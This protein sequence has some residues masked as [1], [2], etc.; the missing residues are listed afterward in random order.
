[1][2]LNDLRDAWRANDWGDAAMDTKKAAPRAPHP[3]HRSGSRK[4]WDLILNAMPEDVLCRTLGLL[5]FESSDAPTD[6]DGVKA[7]P[8]PLLPQSPAAA[9]LGLPEH[10]DLAKLRERAA[11]ASRLAVVSKPWQRLMKATGA[12]ASLVLRHDRLVDTFDNL[13]PIVERLGEGG[14]GMKHLVRARLLFKEEHGREPTAA[15]L[16]ELRAP[17]HADAALK[18]LTASCQ[19]VW[20][21]DDGSGAFRKG[22][23]FDRWLWDDVLP[24]ASCVSL[25][26]CG[27]PALDRLAFRNVVTLDLGF[28]DVDDG[29]LG[30][31]GASSKHTL[32]RLALPMCHRVGSEGAGKLA[33]AGFTKLERLDISGCRLS[34]GDVAVLVASLRSSLRSLDL[35]QCRPDDL[36]PR[37]LPSHMEESYSYGAAVAGDISD[38]RL[39]HFAKE[40]GLTVVRGDATMTIPEEPVPLALAFDPCCVADCV[41][42]AS[43][44][45]PSTL[46]SVGPGRVQLGTGPRFVL[47]A[48]AVDFGGSFHKNRASAALAIADAHAS[49]LR[50][51]RFHRLCAKGTVPEPVNAD[52]VA[53]T[54]FCGM[55]CLVDA[56]FGHCGLTDVGLDLL[57]GAWRSGSLHAL[58]ELDLQRSRVSSAGL[59]ALCDQLPSSLKLRRLDVSRCRVDDA[60]MIA[61]FR[62]GF[63][64]L[65]ILHADE[66]PPLTDQMLEPLRSAQCCPS[67]VALHLRGVKHHGRITQHGVDEVLVARGLPPM[68]RRGP[69]LPGLRGGGLEILGAFATGK[70]PARRPAP[71]LPRHSTAFRGLQDYL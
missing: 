61:I 32:R 3:P 49:T 44:K 11:V 23:Q 7:P 24:L 28:S 22:A 30:H 62:A 66:I 71:R 70:T 40:C 43:T 34:A 29:A 52:V 58:V 18:A 68:D 37:P 54:V 16:G 46:V 41:S 45:Q 47:S 50:R 38:D 36:P 17:G 13:V 27:C 25:R 8:P 2:S 51:C 48:V 31:I 39:E 4:R 26:C 1:M 64:S 15:E 67:L 42:L 60:A 59:V 33:G 9:A 12:F 65:R 55:P 5:L 56:G 10:A 6:E 57:G 19:R 35:S 53:R 21:R 20:F 69:G 63:D 14:C